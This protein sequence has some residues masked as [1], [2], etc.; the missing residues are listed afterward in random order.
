MKNLLI[1]T[2]S[3]SGG[4]TE[5]VSVTLANFL[6]EQG[7]NVNIAVFRTGKSG[8]AVN[9][10]I[11]IHILPGC[12]IDSGPSIIRK[13]YATIMDYAALR[14]IIME[15][16]I[17][18]IISFSNPPVILMLLLTMRLSIISSKRNYPPES[19]SA[20]ERQIFRRSKA[21]VFQT[22]EQ[23]EYYDEK[24]RKKGVVIPNPITGNL[25]EPYNG[26]RRK[27]IITFC[28][29]AKQK[30]LKMLIDGFIKFHATFPDYTLIIYGSRS[31]KDSSH[32]EELEEHINANKM[33]QVIKIKE[34]T[35]D[36]HQLIADSAC[37][38]LTSDF[39]GISNSMLEAMAIGLPVICTD[40]KGGGA[41]AFIK[42]Y[43]NG[44]LIP[45]ND[46]E[47]LSQALVYIA[48]NPEKAQEMGKKAV[49][50]K[51]T[52]AMEKTCGKWLEIPGIY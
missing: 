17:E 22:P 38:A 35:H 50:I 5:R 6:A 1:I 52:L 9:G 14:K 24:T 41:N 28:R 19:S 34:F 51:E 31:L 3:L 29:L 47:A 27:E 11:S 49:E 10:N 33:G 7:H 8:Y 13:L 44:I 36:I 40:C 30:N 48:S 37:F 18:S 46:R 42:N 43:E 4:G 15:N 39:E 12:K 32:L 45:V 21:I 20:M 2:G 26:N 16:K 23:M 25:P